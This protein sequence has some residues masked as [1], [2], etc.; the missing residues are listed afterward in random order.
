[1]TPDADTARRW[2]EDELARGIYTER[3]GLV[4][5][6]IDWVL[7]RLDTLTEM[8]A[9][10]GGWMLPVAVVLLT[11]VAVI[12]ALVVGP[13]SR[14]RRTAGPPEGVLAG[15][16]R[17]AEQL[18][19]AADAA[20][21]R[22][23]F[24]AAVLDRFRAMIRS[25]VDR[26]LLDD[27]PGLTADEAASEGGRRLP[28]LRTELGRAAVVFDRVCYGGASADGDDDAWLRELDALL[29]AARPSVPDAS[30][31]EPRP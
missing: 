21:A 27:R 17:T 15:E 19:A 26:A 7:D 16:T 31:G 6:A 3:T 1:M 18:R 30:A 22:A 10:G 14:R 23:D 2:A 8:S 24:S 29:R 20:A 5:R 25:L 13:P 11:A 9:T 12:V 28:T 4:E